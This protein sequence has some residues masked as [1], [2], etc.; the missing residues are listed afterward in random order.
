MCAWL[1]AIRDKQAVED[2]VFQIT[3]I[4]ETTHVK[5]FNLS[6]ARRRIIQGN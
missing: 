5:R 4:K 1:Q 2:C 3:Q 6:I